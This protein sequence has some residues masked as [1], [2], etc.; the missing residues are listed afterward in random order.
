M[1]TKKDQPKPSEDKPRATLETSSGGVM[2]DGSPEKQKQ[3]A[4]GSIGML[5]E[6]DSNDGNETKI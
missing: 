2:V 5:T 3:G 6:D 4:P 1:A